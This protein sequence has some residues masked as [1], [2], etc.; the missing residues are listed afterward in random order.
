MLY[1]IYYILYTIHYILYTIYYILY[2]IYCTLYTIY[3]ILYN[4]YT[5]LYY[6]LLVLHCSL[7]SSGAVPRLQRGGLHHGHHDSQSLARGVA[8]T[9]LL[10]EVNLKYIYIYTCVHK[11]KYIYIYVYI[12]LCTHFLNNCQQRLKE[13]HEHFQES[14]LRCMFLRC[15][16]HGIHGYPN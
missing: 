4:Y 13:K 1:T 2:T 5:M 10:W 12:H 14:Q 8:L 6:A 3:Y 16:Q 7:L 9:W 11:Y 15:E